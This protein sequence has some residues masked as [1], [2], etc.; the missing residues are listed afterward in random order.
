MT[1]IDVTF[2]SRGRLEPHSTIK[3]PV[4]LKSRNYFKFPDI[5]FDPTSNYKNI[6]LV[7]D[8]PLSE[9]EF[10]SETKNLLKECRMDLG[11]DKK[12]EILAV[13]FFTPRLG[14]GDL[15]DHLEK[16]LIPAVSQSY[17][18]LFPEYEFKN[19]FPHPLS[20]HF[21]SISGLG[22]DRLESAVTLGPVIGVCLFI[23]REY[24]VQAARDQVK[25][26]GEGFGLSGA[27]DLSSVLVSQPDLLFH[28]D[29]YPPLLWF[30]GCETTWEHANFHYE[31]YGYNLMFNRRVHYDQV[32]EYWSHGVTRFIRL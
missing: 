13:P 8:I 28:K 11:V 6:N 16:K 18:N 14:E 7:F 20:E 1:K 30:S 26:L 23:I 21:K 19:E 32:A 12:Q 5:N 2:D 25:L 10:V 22:H 27:I 17:K 9:N 15:G 31:A 3:T 24:S 29:D 4:H